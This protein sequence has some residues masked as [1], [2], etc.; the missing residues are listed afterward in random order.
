MQSTTKTTH[1]FIQII[2]CSIKV[3]GELEGSGGL[4]RRAA[5]QPL[6]AVITLYSVTSV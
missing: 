1:K 3:G 6:T 5:R 4:Q 2:R